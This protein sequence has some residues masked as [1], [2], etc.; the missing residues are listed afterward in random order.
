MLFDNAASSDMDG[1]VTKMRR[2]LEA[3]HRRFGRRLGLTSSLVL[4]VS[5]A[6][7]WEHPELP[8]CVFAK[9]INRP[10]GGLLIPDDHFFCNETLIDAGAG[11]PP[12]YVCLSQDELVAFFRK[13]CAQEFR[14]RAD[15]AYFRG[16]D[17]GRQGKWAVRREL[18]DRFANSGG[19]VIDVRLGPPRVSQKCYCRP[20]VLLNLPGNQ[21]WSYRMRELFL[22]GSLVV[23]VVVHVSYD[24]GKTYNDRWVQWWSW[25]L[26]PGADYIQVD[27]RW[28]AGNDSHNA[29]QHALLADRMQRLM[30]EVTEDP[31]RYAAIAASGKARMQSITNRT[32]DK[33]VGGMFA[34]ARGLLPPLA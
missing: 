24:G 31:E 16:A 22:T 23:D 4:Y 26:T 28:I 9:P 15:K 5:D 30:K 32:V 3:W 13:E 33:Y 2:Y 14:D 12:R 1:R 27:I 18:A 11:Q 29:V 8:A 34:H 19:T 25:A 6:Y 10:R 21:P 7:L 17:T 20:K